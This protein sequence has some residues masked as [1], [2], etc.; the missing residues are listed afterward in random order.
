MSNHSTISNNSKSKRL[1]FEFLSSFFLFCSGIYPALLK[2]C[3]SDVQKYIGIGATVFFTGVLAFMSASYAIFTVFNS[4]IV[5]IFFGLIWGVMIFNLDRYLVSSMRKSD[6]KVKDFLSATPRILL[7]VLIAVVISKPLEVKLFDTEIQSELVL[8]E[9]ERFLTQENVAKQRY[10]SDIQAGNQKVAELDFMLKLEKSKVGALLQSAIAEADGTGGSGKRNMGPIYKMKKSEADAAQ[11]AYGRLNDSIQT[12]ISTEAAIVN[13]L[14]TQSNTTLS[15]LQET[16]L[17]GLASRLNA[18]GRIS[19]TNS[20]IYWASIFIMLL[21][22]AVECS[23]IL[24]KLITKKGPYDYML[25]NLER[26]YQC[27]AEKEI[28]LLALESDVD[29][30]YAKKTKS[31]QNRIRIEAE[32]EIYKVA[33]TNTKNEILGKKP[34]WS[35]I[36][37]GV[38]QGSLGSYQ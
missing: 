8:M 21:F 11:V 25:E 10:T 23:P 22:I 13:N 7:A 32:N 35:D 19:N 5:S 37:D 12:I 26:K 29:Q 33:L 27:K 28:A 4:Y 18:L 14:K 16:A 36:R 6:S 17:T 2:R 20:T 15:N 34:V 38:W 24:V 3:P 30:S 1:S 9:Q 31:L